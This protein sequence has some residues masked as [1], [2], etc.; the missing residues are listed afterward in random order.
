[1]VKVGRECGIG[2]SGWPPVGVSVSGRLKLSPKYPMQIPPNFGMIVLMHSRPV[3]EP[4]F[5]LPFSPIIPERRLLAAILQRAIMDLGETAYVTFREVELS[6]EWVFSDELCH[7][8]FSF[9]FV[10]EQ[11]DLCVRSVREM[12]RERMP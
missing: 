1:M 6:H 10:C 7:L 2:R 11:L 3:Q 4:E 5:E 8:P 12:V 9:H